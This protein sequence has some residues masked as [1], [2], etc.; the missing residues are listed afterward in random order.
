MAPPPDSRNSGIADRQVAAGNLALNHITRTIHEFLA[1]YYFENS[2]L[3]PSELGTAARQH[4]TIAEAIERRD[5]IAAAEAMRQHLLW[6]QA[7]EGV[8]T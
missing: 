1:T 4:A 2:R 7:H 6:A 5:S 3:L 8:A